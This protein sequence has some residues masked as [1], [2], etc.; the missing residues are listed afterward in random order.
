MF[1][2]EIE[3]CINKLTNKTNIFKE[4]KVKQ[5]VKWPWNGPGHKVYV[6]TVH[7][8][9]NTNSSI[10]G[11]YEII[12]QGEGAHHLDP[13]QID[14]G[15]YAH[16]YQFEELVC[17]NRL[18]KLHN[19]SYAYTGDPIIYDEAGVYPMID[20]PKNTTFQPG[21]RCYTQARAFHRVYR[22]LLRV[23]QKTF[24]GEP[25]EIS[26]AVKL[27]ESLLVHAK[28]CISTPYSTP[29]DASDYN[30]GPAWD[31]EWD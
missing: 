23:L 2:K 21:S 14:T 9:N 10:S 28:R 19:G 12:E 16:F 18:K 11:I 22:N 4:P 7:I 30:C 25:E 31:Y 26:E 1:Y 27:M 17:Q 20:D 15:M 5:Q 24:N 29:Y 6:G 8:I 3:T 13:K